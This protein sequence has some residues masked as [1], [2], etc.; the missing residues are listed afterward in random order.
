MGEIVTT[1]SKW[2]H[3][4][5]CGPI[6]KCFLLEDLQLMTYLGEFLDYVILIFSYTV[7]FVFDNI[8]TFC[9]GIKMYKKSVVR[10]V[11]KIVLCPGATVALNKPW[12]QLWFRIALTAA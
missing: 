1:W 8:N 10:E 11:L 3:Q 7:L 6:L 9:I 12:L 4:Q 5:L 2:L